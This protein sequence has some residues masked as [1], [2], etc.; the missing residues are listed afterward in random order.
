MDQQ[1]DDGALSGSAAKVEAA[2]GDFAGQTKE[3]AQDAR[4]EAKP[5]LRNLQASAGDAVNKMSDLAR[6]ASNVGLQTASQAGDAIQGVAREVGSQAYQQ[7]ARAQGY[8]T[9]FVMEQP[10]AALLV[11]GAIGYGLAYLMLRRSTG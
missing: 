8:V 11:A 5:V 1:T 2:A 3:L 9:Q 10:L 4:E 7:G 6:K